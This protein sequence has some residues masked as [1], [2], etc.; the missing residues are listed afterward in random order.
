MICRIRA[1]KT[2][3]DSMSMHT[4]IERGKMK[5]KTLEDFDLI[6]EN[7]YGL[8]TID[9]DGIVT[10]INRQVCNF[11]GIDYEWASSGRH[12]NEVFPFSKMTE[13]LRTKEPSNMEFYHYNGI[14]SASM[15]HPLIKD[16]EMVGVIEYDVF[17]D[18]EMVEAFVNHY[19]DL[20]EEI[21]YYKEA[22]RDYQQ[23][24]YSL[25]NIVGKSVPMLNLKEKIKIVANSNST[26]LVTGETGTGKELVAHS[27]HDASKRR[28]RN[29]IKMNAASLPESLAESELFGYTEG[30]FTGAR[31]GGKKG[32]FEM[33]NHGTLF[34]DEIN[35]MPLSL[36]P[37]LLRALQEGEID[38]VG[39]A[40]SIP[41]DVRIIA[42]TNKDL[43]E[44]V[45]R[46]EFREDLYYRLNVVEL[47]VPP[48]RERK[49]DIKELVDLFIE[50]QNNMLGKQVTGIEDK[51]IET[52]KKYD[53]PGNVRELQ[54]VIEKTMNYA[55]GNVIRDS[56]LIFSMGSQT[57]TI[58]K[59]K[60]YDSPIEIAKRSA[61]RELILETLDKVGGNKSQ[62][63]KLLKI[64]RPLLY[65][66]ME[67]LGIK[68]E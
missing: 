32:K 60:D 2:H 37:K 51:A 15:R 50:Q 18:M 67:R 27:I 57:P 56:E 17:Y 65:Q 14:T 47:E 45:D 33:A 44:M 61:E 63:A 30:A 36:Q 16:G 8:V 10:Y 28:L 21:K 55:V 48:L 13:T 46:G 35:A 52:L 12:V 4:D 66:K 58:N 19:I 7:V 29:F 6:M 1:V 54:N 68:K 59:L 23:T 9:M 22:A 41:V 49:E 5:Y 20:D 64:S 62:A 3:A 11:C 53:W 24:K 39:S 40:E 26:V 31:K 38:R 42:A 43:K 34:I 25:D